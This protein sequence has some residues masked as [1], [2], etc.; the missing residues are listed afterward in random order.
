MQSLIEQILTNNDV[1]FSL[2]LLDELVHGVGEDCPD[3]FV[4]NSD[5]S[6]MYVTGSELNH[7]ST[8]VVAAVDLQPL[9]Y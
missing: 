5:D 3:S 2:L 4:S 9:N 7:E 1:I 8:V 6:E